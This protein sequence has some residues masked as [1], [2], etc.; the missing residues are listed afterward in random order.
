MY[1]IPRPK[2]LIKLCICSILRSYIFLNDVIQ[3]SMFGFDFHMPR[4]LFHHTGYAT[5]KTASFASAA[6]S[7]SVSTKQ[8]L[9]LFQVPDTKVSFRVVNKFGQTHTKVGR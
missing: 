5:R 8:L 4:L 1:L 9:P 7:Y 6:F 3:K 2:C